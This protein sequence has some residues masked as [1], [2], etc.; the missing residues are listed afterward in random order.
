MNMSMKSNK[1]IFIFF[2]VILVGTFISSEA[3]VK[4]T[5]GAVL[6]LDANSLLELESTNKGL[7]IPRMAINDINLAAPLTAPV[8]AGMLVYSIGGAVTDG[9][10]Y[11]NGSQW[12]KFVQA[13]LQVNEGGTGLTSGTSGGIP[14]YTGITTITSSGLLTQNA[15]VIGGGAGATPSTITLGTSNK[16]LG[17]N[18]GA[19]ANEYKTLNGTTN[20]ISVSNAAGSITLSA[21]QDINTTSSPTFAGLTLTNPLIV[22]NGGTGLALGTS[23]GIP[24]YTGSTTITS[25]GLLTQNALVVGG[26]TGA[27]PSTIS[28]GTAGQVLT[29]NGVS[30]P[31]WQETEKIVYLNTARTVTGTTM[32]DVTGLSFTAEANK[33]YYVEF[34]I[35]YTTSAPTRGIALSVN[36]PASPTG[37]AF[38]N[39]GFSSGTNIVGR[40]YN[41]YDASSNFGNALAG[42]NYA[43]VSGLFRN[44]NN[45]GTLILR[46][47]AEVAASTA[48]VEIG[49]ILKYR[50]LN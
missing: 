27:T 34:N 50:K 39:V 28:T 26:G 45:S 30:A 29:S 46:F 3:Q 7:L 38:Q 23:G 33:D 44:G 43:T 16:L 2:T 14:S 8:P 20:R 4:I 36:G 19:T 1:F 40:T 47:A 48:T 21:P 25:S 32:T 24:S 31:A 17:M 10:Y 9:F 15:L 49:S 11:W 41:V 18:A 5:D 12:K 42:Y 22:P 6:T 13:T 35:I 37:L